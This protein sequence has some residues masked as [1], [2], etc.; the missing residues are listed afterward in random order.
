MPRWIKSG[1][2]RDDDPTVTWNDSPRFSGQM[3]LVS[4]G[5]ANRRLFLAKDKLEQFRWV[6]A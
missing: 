5:G 6:R 4:R 3:F 1:G 2:N